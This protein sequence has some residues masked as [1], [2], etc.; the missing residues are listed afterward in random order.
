MDNQERSKNERAAPHNTL[1]TH[2]TSYNNFTISQEKVIN[3]N[4]VKGVCGM[5]SRNLM[6]NYVNV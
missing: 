3:F 2:I 4:D 1:F 5:V 6:I